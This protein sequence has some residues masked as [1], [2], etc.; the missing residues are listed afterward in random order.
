MV[1]WIEQ[2]TVWTTWTEWTRSTKLLAEHLAEHV[3][4]RLN[5]EAEA[6]WNQS[7]LDPDE[8]EMGYTFFIFDFI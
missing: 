4:Q 7:P 3:S 1:D 5:P 2:W 8:M 6:E